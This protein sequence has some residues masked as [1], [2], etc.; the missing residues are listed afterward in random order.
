MKAFAM[1]ARRHLQDPK[2]FVNYGCEHG[3][4]V[5]ERLPKPRARTRHPNLMRANSVSVVG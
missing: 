4:R 3:N 1:R 2:V 5:Y